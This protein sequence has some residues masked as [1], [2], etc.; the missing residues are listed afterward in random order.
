MARSLVA[1]FVIFLFFHFNPIARAQTESATAPPKV[2]P[3][4][5]PPTL[6]LDE[7]V[8]AA[9]AQ[10]P[11]LRRAR[12][13]IAA[14]DART[15]QARSGYFPQIS[16][17]G[18]AK[19]GLSGAS[20]ALGLR[21]LVTSPLFRDIGASAAIFQNI[22]DFGRTAH[23]VKA[24]RWAAVS[25]NHA[26][27]AQ[28]A[29]VT[30]NVQQAYYTALQQQRLVKVSE[31]ILADRQLIVRQASAFYKAEIKSKVDVTLAEVGAANANLELVEARDRLRTAIAS[32]NHAMGI[33]GE[34]EYTL[35]EPQIIV[36]AAPALQPLLAASRQ[37]RPE[38]LAL[39]AQIKADEEIVL[40][41]EKEKWPK[42]MALFSSGWVRFSD[43][44]PGKLLLGAFGVDLP[45]STGGRIENVVAEAQANLAQTRAAR[46]ELAQDIRFQA[47][48]AYNELLSGIETVRANEQLIAQA[49]E[50]LRL[51]NVRYRVQ[52]GSFVE[53]TSAEA[54]ASRAEAHYA[55]ALYKYKM[56]EARLNYLTGRPYQP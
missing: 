22:F 10:H 47:Q 43:L 7:A 54:A 21:G 26:L 8:R 46:D 39:D 50:A 5:L 30:L 17:S 35:A 4:T 49:R 15:K 14:A 37:Q 13:A 29:L 40:R 24:S 36:A 51:A 38:L 42:L 19:Q 31:Q 28:Q 11:S 53:L 18:I 45:L 52:L 6:K 16:T 1:L 23:Q 41:A 55:Q 27:A 20:G 44:S 12:E 32:L 3:S 9:L 25:L 48:R 34:P 2:E 56:A 33:D